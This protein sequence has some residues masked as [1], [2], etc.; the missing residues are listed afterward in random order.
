[1][2]SACRQVEDRT[3]GLELGADAY[4]TKHISPRELKA[5]VRALDRR[6]AAQPSPLSPA[7][8]AN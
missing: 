5:R 6:L 8:V 2:V 3:V 1:V 4:I 7:R